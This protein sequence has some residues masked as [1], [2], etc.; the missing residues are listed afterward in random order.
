MK[1]IERRIFLT[2]IQRSERSIANP[3][4][5]LFN[6]SQIKNQ[7]MTLCNVSSEMIDSIL[8]KWKTHKI[9]NDIDQ[10]SRICELVTTN[11]QGE[12]LALYIYHDTKGPR[13]KTQKDLYVEWLE[14]T[15]AES[16]KVKSVPSWFKHELKL[17]FTYFISPIVN[18]TGYKTTYYI[19]D[20]EDY[21]NILKSIE[22]NSTYEKM[23]VEDYKNDI[24]YKTNDY[25]EVIAKDFEDSVRQK[26][27]Y[28]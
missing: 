15:G 23:S 11:F 3:N 17:H 16:C 19:T 5:L 7:F 24:R 10:N 8:D 21:T 27:I 28:F 9:I 2:A 26:F 4:I 12:Y 18:E 25:T 13:I 6:I 20:E 22:S 14:L 1:N